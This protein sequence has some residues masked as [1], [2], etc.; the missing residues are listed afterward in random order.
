MRRM[1]FAPRH[2]VWM[3]LVRDVWHQ[4]GRRYF[5]QFIGKSLLL[6]LISLIENF[7]NAFKYG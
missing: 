7:Q 2:V 1:K 3:M 5:A 6:R 4:C